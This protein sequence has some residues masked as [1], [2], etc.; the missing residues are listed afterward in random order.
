MDWKSMPEGKEKYQAYLCSREWGLKKEAVRKRCGGI[1]ER[2]CVN[3]MDHTHHLTYARKYNELLEDLR[4]LCKPC[5]DFTHG[6][7]SYDPATSGRVRV[8]GRFVKTFYLAGKI[9]GNDWRDEIVAN[10]SEENHSEHNW[11]A[12]HDYEQTRLWNTAPNAA[13]ARNGVLLHYTGP[14]W[15]PVLGGHSC[16]SW[17]VSPHAYLVNPKDEYGQEPKSP[18]PAMFSEIR[19]NIDNAISQ[20]DLV[21]AWI[22]SADCFGTLVELGFAAAIKKAIVVAFSEA[23]D[24]S[25]FWL[26]ASY[27]HEVV[28]AR[29]A[30]EAW[31]KAWGIEVPSHSQEAV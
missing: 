5:H 16:S 11:R 20:A 7:A 21:F 17:F 15:S 8:A 13:R 22:D 28:V 4:A 19:R 12:T 14:W 1:C 2:C 10:W 18:T 25:E 30:G 6:K 26:A 29:T 23:V 31:A 3:A 27:A 24:F 9:S